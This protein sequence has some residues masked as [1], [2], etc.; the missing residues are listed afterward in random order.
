[1]SII[2][3]QFCTLADK[4]IIMIVIKFWLIALQ[5]IFEH[6]NSIIC[7]VEKDIPEH[8]IHGVI[9]GFHFLIIHKYVFCIKNKMKAKEFIEYTK[10]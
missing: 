4:Y 8:F 5:I 7:S 10:Y 6:F 2:A 1:M 9:L 3:T